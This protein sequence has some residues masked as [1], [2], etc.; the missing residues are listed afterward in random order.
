MKTVENSL[1]FFR[2]FDLAFFAPGVVIVTT[3]CWLKQDDLVIFGKG[4]TTPLGILAVLSG[5]G[6][7]YCAGLITHCFT[8]FILR[9]KKSKR[10]EEM[11]EIGGSW[12]PMA[13]LFE[14][15]LRDDLILYFWY[16][17]ATCLNVAS[18]LLLSIILVLAIKGFEP[19]LLIAA[20]VALLAACLLVIQGHH[21]DKSVKRSLRHRAIHRQSEANRSTQD[22][23]I[24]GNAKS[25][26]R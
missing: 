4:L 18:A 11:N 16:L 21:F 6:A 3:V 14:D 9:C 20:A 2:V 10:P 5:I 7:I 24:S 19:N 26:N 12:P 23:R 22:S 13:L 25:N 1:T 8:W 17:R 15:A